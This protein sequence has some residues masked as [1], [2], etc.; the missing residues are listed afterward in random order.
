MLEYSMFERLPFRSQAEAIAK[1]GTILA[2]RQYNKWL[3]TLY[4]FN[5]TFVE[6]WSGDNVQVFSTFKKS[7]NASA[8]FDPYLDQVD[9]QD[10]SIS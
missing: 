7:A 4:E 9:V 10:L 2:Q 6:L 3:V 5:N 8:I 1:D